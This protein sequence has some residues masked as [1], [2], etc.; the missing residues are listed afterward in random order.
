MEKAILFEDERLQIGII[1]KR[2]QKG[3]SAEFEILLHIGNKSG[4]ESL[5]FMETA[6]LND[7][8]KSNFL[9]I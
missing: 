9:C 2:K 5:C 7:K 1:T 8:C 3:I 6:I 4:E